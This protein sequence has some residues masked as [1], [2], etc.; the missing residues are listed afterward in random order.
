LDHLS[1]EADDT[2]WVALPKEV[3]DAFAVSKQLSAEFHHLNVNV[4]HLMFKTRGPIETLYIVLRQ[5]SAQDLSRK[6]ISLDSS[7]LY[8]SDIL[9]VF[10]R[11][12]PAVGASFYFVQDKKSAEASAVYSYIRLENGR[13]CGIAEKQAIS[14]FANTGAYG[15][16]TAET[17]KEACQVAM[18]DKE[19]GS[20][21]SNP[22][23]L[24]ISNAISLMMRRHG[25]EFMGVHVPKFANVGREERL[26]SFLL[27]VRQGNV[28]MFSQRRIRF[29]FDL[30]GTLVT[31]PK[32][33]DDWA[34]VEPIEQNIAL[35]KQ[36]HEAGH[37]IIVQTAR[38]MRRARGNMG[39]VMKLAGASTFATLEEFDIPY[40]ELIFGKPMADIY[41]G[42]NHISSMANTIRE[43]G[44]YIDPDPEVKGLAGAVAPRDF[45]TVRPVDDNHVFKS[46][47][48]DVMLGETH[49]YRSIPTAIGDL[50]PVPIKIEDDGEAGGAV[51]LIMSKVP[52]VTF[53]QLVVNGALTSGRMR[54]MLQGIRRI[55][56]YEPADPSTPLPSPEEIA[57]NYG[58]KVRSRYAKHQEFYA[59]FVDKVPE[60]ESMF[61]A[62]VTFLERYVSETR[63]TCA[64]FIHGDPVFSNCI[65][66]SSGGVRFIDMRGSLGGRLTTQGDRLY[67][68]SKI[69]QSLCGYDAMLLDLEI[70]DHHEQQLKDLQAVFWEE[71]ADMIPDVDFEQLKRDVILITA[72]HLFTIVPLHEVRSRQEAYLLRS[73][74]LLLESGVPLA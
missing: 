74:Q 38:G 4:V 27:H 71:V 69:F 65:N 64:H 5:M 73:R 47:P 3:D 44:W 26:Q 63:F 67:D 57:S 53:S 33:P 28:P 17:L 59:S 7:T 45:N 10:R 15:F 58:T 52:G 31:N 37:H 46:G 42:Q 13:I 21:A 18:D 60:T 50:F 2:I 72:S 70:S 49:W 30:D 12:P 55:H 56:E 24:Y 34:S 23:Q 43:L 9:N 8:F 54:A 29:C 20:G 66:V 40:D 11:V 19:G 62:I 36:L 68:L 25:I 14:R 51:S 22:A 41:I 32:T 61:S 6:T 16:P 1:L 39:E 48:R 35:V